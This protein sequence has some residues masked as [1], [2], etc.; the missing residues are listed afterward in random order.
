M[1]LGLLFIPAVLVAAVLGLAVGAMLGGGWPSATLLVGA[2]VV[3]LVL[4][5]IVLRPLL[6]GLD[7]I[8]RNVL[9]ML[10]GGAKV[11]EVWTANPLVNNLWRSIVRLDRRHRERQ[12]QLEGD[13]EAARAVL[14]ALPDPLVLVDDERRIRR[15]NPPASELFG[16]GLVSRDLATAIRNPGVLAAVD[17]TLADDM[18]RLVEF[19][20]SAP[21]ARH[22][23][24][25]VERVH[26]EEA[27]ALV[28]LTDLTALKRAEQLRADFVANASH[29][30]RTPLSAVIGFIETLEGPAADDAEARTRFLPI[31]RQQAGRMARLVDDLLSLSRIELNEHLPPRES[32]DLGPVLT[33]VTR[34]LE[35]KAQTREIRIE[36][37]VTAP[38]L[39]VAGDEEEL[40]QVFQNLI[41]NAIKYGAAGSAITVTAGPSPKLSGGVAVAVQDR[42]EGIA[43][44]HIPR[45]TERFYRVDS[46]RSRAM[47][48]TGLGLAIVK[49]I[50]SRHRG[51]LEIE[52]ELGLGS[53]FTVHLPPALAAPEAA[54]SS[55]PKTGT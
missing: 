39:P 23:R 27:A 26:G 51:V 4:Q 1:P 55:L 15:V 49:H 41:D 14:A 44:E 47:G 13:L 46:A 24:A 52:S 8:R 33:D 45:L 21:V 5:I 31:M 11:S 10:E 17:A 20:L 32:V 12:G 34:S 42:G 53:R 3:L 38:E 2:A 16:H 9:R 22:F 54:P 36:L 48:G 50:V 43:R 6:L 7:R 28:A 37:G 30:L 18:P 25:R 19:E 29:E 40:A 35:L